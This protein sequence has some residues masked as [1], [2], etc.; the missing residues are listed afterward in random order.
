ML[1]RETRPAQKLYL[2][3]RVLRFIKY[4][5]ITVRDVSHHRSGAAAARAEQGAV[6]AEQELQRTTCV[7]MTVGRCPA[8]W[9][10]VVT[11]GGQQQEGGSRSSRQEGGQQ[12][13]EDGEK[14]PRCRS[15]PSTLSPSRLSMGAG[16]V[17]AATSRPAPL[18]RICLLNADTRPSSHLL[19]CPRAPLTTCRTPTMQCCWAWRREWNERVRAEVLKVLYVIVA[20]HV[21]PLSLYPPP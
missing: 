16:Q 12:E 20:Y 17:A 2:P 11:L 19:W 18:R 4:D 14:F 8:V 13:G 3:V 9:A 7:A 15:N 6:K 21:M 5:G 1:C 10:G